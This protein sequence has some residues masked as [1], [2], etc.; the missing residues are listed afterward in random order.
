MIRER[1]KRADFGEVEAIMRLVPDAPP[2]ESDEVIDPKSYA[3]NG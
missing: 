1:A 2:D 3:G